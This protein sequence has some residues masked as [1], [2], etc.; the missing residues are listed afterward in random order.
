MQG[1]GGSVMKA[2]DIGGA[3][4]PQRVARVET[5]I[6]PPLFVEPWLLSEFAFDAANLALTRKSRRRKGKSEQKGR[7]WGLAR[8]SRSPIGGLRVTVN[9]EAGER[10]ESDKLGPFPLR[11]DALRALRPE[12]RNR[13]IKLKFAPRPR[14]GCS[15]DKFRPSIICTLTQGEQRTPR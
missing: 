1:G 14:C 10:E 7:R 9:G 4:A 6:H 13:V 12:R 8:R 15:F 5:S 3:V 11:R 2:L